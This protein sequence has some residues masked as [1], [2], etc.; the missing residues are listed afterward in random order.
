M[1]SSTGSVAPRCVMRRWVLLA[2]L[3]LTSMVARGQ[4]VTLVQTTVRPGAVVSIDG[5][6]FGAKELVDI[7]LDGQAQMLGV[8]RRDGGFGR[9]QWTLPDS[10]AL[11]AH[12]VTVVGRQSAKQGQAALNVGV[13][14]S[15]SQFNSAKTGFN[16]FERIL[17]PDNVGRL[18]LAWAFDTHSGINSSALVVDGV[19]YCLT[20]AP[21]T[22][23]AI[24]SKTGALAWSVSVS[25]SANFS[26]FSIGGDILLLGSSNGYL[27]A[28]NK[29]TGAALWSQSMGTSVS[30]GVV[31]DGMAYVAAKAGQTNIVALDVQTGAVRWTQLGSYSAPVEPI[32]VKNGVL[33]YC[34]SDGWLSAFD[35]ATGTE[36]W[37]V[38]AGYSISLA[39]VVARGKVFVH[40]WPDELRAFDAQTGQLLWRAVPSVDGYAL[41][42]PGVAYGLVFVTCNNGLCAF[43]ELTGAL[44]WYG[45]V[46][47]SS[48]F[49]N[50]TVAN[51]LVYTVDDH[52]VMHVFDAQ[53]GVVRANLAA[54]RWTA[55]GSV[56]VT[57]GRAY[58]GS[59]NGYLYAFAL[60][61]GKNPAYQRPP[62]A[63]RPLGRSGAPR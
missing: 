17:N 58:Y 38:P 32:A 40:S 20:F 10:T 30:S 27:Y 26:S 15:A 4:S 52:A 45:D 9:Y 16:P 37:K 11:G 51:G 54:G 19:I 28:F 3:L 29:N 31:V 61:G 24:D 63:A 22:L 43:D 55:A 41:S 60:D 14:W 46:G 53:T 33:F 13:N 18:S 8:T 57:D 34:S 25:E 48:T 42:A 62:P 2:T 7:Y 12:A 36:L 21:S 1:S 47:A 6:G 23:Q 44:R 56:T 59:G 49:A 35:A 50:P 5:A 39:P